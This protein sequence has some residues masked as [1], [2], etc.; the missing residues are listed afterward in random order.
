M[1]SI[2]GSIVS[3]DWFVNSFL[4]YTIIQHDVYKVETI[5]DAY[6]VVGGVPEVCDNHAERVLNVSI[7]TDRIHKVSGRLPGN[8]LTIPELYSYLCIRTLLG[9][10][11]VIVTKS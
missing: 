7:G 6:M 10:G 5:G 4:Y 8:L 2:S 9:Y 3:L 11:T 1:I